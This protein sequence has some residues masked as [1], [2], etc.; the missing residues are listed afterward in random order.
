MEVTAPEHTLQQVEALLQR[1]RTDQARS[2]LKSAL[3]QHPDHT[4]LLLQSAW[5]DYFDDRNE[6][7][8]ATVRQVLVTEPQNPSARQLYFELLM[9]KR[10]HAEAERVIL[11]LLRDY[12][13]QAHFYGRYAG[14]MLDVLRLPKARALAQEG[15]KYEPDDGECLAVQTICD[16]I[17]Q[18]GGATSH[19]LQQLL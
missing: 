13:E 12:P 14:L 9:Q 6:E 11:E 8:L 17:E 16:F 4:G 5:I 1:R 2:L 19:G 18:P 15:L 10:E 7:S 3:A